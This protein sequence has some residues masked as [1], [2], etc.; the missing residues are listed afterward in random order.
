MRDHNE[1][2]E[3][4]KVTMSIR[5]DRADTNSGCFFCTDAMNAHTERNQLNLIVENDFHFT[6]FCPY[7]EMQ[8]LSRLLNNW[9]RRHRRRKRPW[10]IPKE[11]L[12]FICGDILED[13]KEP[14]EE[15]DATD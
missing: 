4:H 9:A 15:R 13:A 6:E 1:A 5:R 2:D 7:H 14:E 3:I 12:C 8:L 11:D 10:P